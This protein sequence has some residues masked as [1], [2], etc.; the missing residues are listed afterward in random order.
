MN[1][2]GKDWGIVQNK[3]KLHFMAKNSMS[4]KYIGISAESKKNNMNNF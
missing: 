3:N 1:Y 4:I 2:K